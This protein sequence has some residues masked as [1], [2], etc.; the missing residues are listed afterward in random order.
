MLI[1]QAWFQ[2]FY[3]DLVWLRGFKAIR[4]VLPSRPAAPSLPPPEETVTA[5]IDAVNTARV[6]YLK[7]TQCLQTSAAV[8]R[9]LRSRG[10]DAE[11]VIGAHL[12]PMR[13]H[14]WVEV[15]GRVVTDKIEEQEYFC[16]LDR[17]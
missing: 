13:A 10:V 15:A 14:A 17:W 9:L 4:D 5:V 6:I 8:T 3:L 12:M 7:P 11:L 16:I 1:A 2:L